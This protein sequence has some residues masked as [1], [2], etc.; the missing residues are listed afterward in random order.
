MEGWRFV[1]LELF[2]LLLLFQLAFPLPFRLVLLCLWFY[3]MFLQ[4]HTLQV[5][6]QHFK[7]QTSNSEAGMSTS[8]DVPSFR[9][10]RFQFKS[11][12]D[13]TENCI[14]LSWIQFIYEGRT[15]Y[16]KRVENPRGNSPY[17]E[18]CSNLLREDLT[19]KWL[20][21]LFGMHQTSTLVFDFGSAVKVTEYS[22]F[23]ANDFPSR[24]PM[25]WLL[26]GSEDGKIW[27]VL[28]QADKVGAPFDRFFSYDKRGLHGIVSSMNG[29]DASQLPYFNVLPKA[30]TAQEIW[31][32][33]EV[34]R[35]EYLLAKK[36][37]CIKK[38]IMGKSTLQSSIMLLKKILEQKPLNENFQ[39]TLLR[40]IQK[41]YNLS[42]ASQAYNVRCPLEGHMIYHNI[43]SLFS[44]FEGDWRKPILHAAL[45]ELG[46]YED[47]TSCIGLLSLLAKGG[48]DC[49]AR[50][51]MAF[52]TLLQ[53]VYAQHQKKQSEEK[54]IK[55]SEQNPGNVSLNYLFQYLEDYIEEYKLLA[56]RSAFL[57]PTKL[58]FN[59]VRDYVLRDDVEV[60]G[61]NTYAAVL[62]STL[63]IQL[64]FPP[65]LN[66]EVKGCCDF[67]SASVLSSQY[68][69]M[70]ESKNFGKDLRLLPKCQKINSHVPFIK[71]NQFIFDG[72]S[73]L[74][75]ANSAISLDP[76]QATQRNTLA[77][78][79]ERY[80]QFFTPQ[81]FLEKA[82][83]KMYSDPSCQHHLQV[84]LSSLLGEAPSQ[85][86]ITDWLYDENYSFQIDKANKLFAFLGII[87]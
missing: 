14:Q 85:T 35:P 56:F 47:E 7:K 32:T 74:S 15:I 2:S 11:I 63:G 50:K 79:L 9:F 46:T 8:V 76:K 45:R 59:A 49:L 12:R 21:S 44:T 13:E 52:H 57:E 42:H 29:Y 17:R 24:D 66:D 3:F 33:N 34:V 1:V 84:I 86:S 58:Y 73:P 38:E 43:S 70:V 72:Q 19:T 75:I 69:E 54:P 80:T 25:S 65:V 20:D 27:K 87:S 48:A 16:P 68:E 61:S 6:K 55:N 81:L 78:Y 30:D 62:L 31:S 28:D 40:L 37:V 5:I 18:Q 10:Y 23:T 39:D 71:H 41:A 4:S 26:E 83:M 51:M 53:R 67:L 22:L 77:K 64:P 36:N 60:H 82:F